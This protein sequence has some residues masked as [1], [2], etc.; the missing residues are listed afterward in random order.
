MIRDSRKLCSPLFALLFFVFVS[1]ALL[2]SVT[3]RAGDADGVQGYSMR[4][5]NKDF[6]NNDGPSG[7]GL[8]IVAGSGTKAEVR[9]PQLTGAAVISHSV[10]VVA[11]LEAIA[12]WM[13]LSVR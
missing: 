9:E 13:W 2:G 12:L 11:R 7:N 10:I 3:A 4:L 6:T 1:T 5:K 8:V